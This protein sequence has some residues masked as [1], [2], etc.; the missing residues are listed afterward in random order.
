MTQIKV[1]YAVLEQAHSQ[2]QAISKALDTKLDTLRS[3][4]QKMEW[5]GQ[6]RVAYQ[7]HQA[8]WDQAVRDLNQVLNEIANAVGVARENYMTT[9]MSNSKLW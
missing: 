5:D 4:L 8:K 6:D 7:Q 3:G 1:D 9:E 2:M